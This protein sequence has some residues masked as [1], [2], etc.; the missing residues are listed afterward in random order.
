MKKKLSKDESIYQLS[1]T[2]IAFVLSVLLVLLLSFRL[3]DSLK[4]VNSQKNMIE[5]LDNIISL[6]LGPSVL[7]P[8]SSDDLMPCNKC[9]AHVRSIPIKDAEK[10]TYIGENIIKSMKKKDLDEKDLYAF[11]EELLKSSKALAQKLFNVS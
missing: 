8:N 6:Y 9:I 11:Y 1:I 10:Y 4:L 5:H 2:E 7:D 3:N